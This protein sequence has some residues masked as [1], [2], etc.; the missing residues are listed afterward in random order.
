[1]F[2]YTVE[3]ND[4]RIL[5][6]DTQNRPTSISTYTYYIGTNA[7][8]NAGIIS[9]KNLWDIK[10]LFL[11]SYNASKNAKIS[12]TWKVKDGIPYLISERSLDCA[13]DHYDI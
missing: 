11:L 10:T 3:A 1:M 7:G 9:A 6:F 12:L 8:I 2:H 13:F 4:H 5:S